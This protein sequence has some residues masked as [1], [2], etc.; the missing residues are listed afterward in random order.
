MEIQ[1]LAKELFQG[2]EV[3]VF[4]TFDKPLFVANDVAK[5]L[6]IKN[7][8]TSIADFEDYQKD[9]VHIMDAIGRLR[10]TTV[11]TESGLLLLI[12]KSNKPFAKEFTKWVFDEVLPTIR[13]T[14][15]YDGQNTIDMQK[16]TEL[17]RSVNEKD[18][19]IQHLERKV[20]E[21]SLG[22]KPEITYHELDLNNFTN[23]A[24]VYLFH[25][26]ENDYKFGVSGGI[27]VR[28]DTHLRD[29]QKEGCNPKLIKVWKCE[30]MQIMKDTELKIKILAKQNN[31]LVAKYGKKEIITTDDIAHVVTCIDKYVNSQNS[32][33]NTVMRIRESEL[34][35]AEINANNESKR[36]DNENLRLQIKLRKLDLQ[37]QHTRTQPPPP[38]KFIELSPA[39]DNIAS[40]EDAPPIQEEIPVNQPLPA[41]TTPAITV[42][43]AQPPVLDKKQLAC[44]WIQANPPYENETTTDYYKRYNTYD[45]NGVKVNSFGPL[46]KTVTKMKTTQGTGGM[47]RWHR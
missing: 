6:D 11:L 34:R 14:G 9:C 5:I 8:R 43:N 29:F 28:H 26:K 46:V 36:L 15:K 35:I 33:E 17:E 7:V 10:P 3:R 24:C 4:G 18:N 19:K 22:Y 31:I 39:D 47:R 12:T 37:S 1:E 32:R 30:N 20:S 2:K 13:R 25:L 23:H 41:I 45:P 44:N 21:L 40:E 38:A 16:Q 27:D 42:L